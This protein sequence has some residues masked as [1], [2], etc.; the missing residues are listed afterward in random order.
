MLMTWLGKSTSTIPVAAS[1]R[2]VIL[3][4]SVC[5]VEQSSLLFNFTYTLLS[6]MANEEAG[7]VTTLF[8]LSVCNRLVKLL[9]HAKV[10]SGALPPPDAAAAVITMGLVSETTVVLLALTLTLGVTAADSTKV[11]CVV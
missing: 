10:N 11:D 4:I 3:S 7:I 8:A 6:P 1:R 5:L 9:S 2:M